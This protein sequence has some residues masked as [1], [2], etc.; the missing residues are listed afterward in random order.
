M[1]R[2]QFLAGAG[3]AGAALALPAWARESADAYYQG[4][5]AALKLH[6]WLGGYAGVDKDLDG[7]PIR[8]EGKLPKALRGTLHRNGPALL[9]RAGQ[10][11][12]HWFDGDGMVQAYEFSDRGLTHRGRFVRTRKFQAESAPASAKRRR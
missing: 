11:Y 2:R 1:A 4:F 3:F 10:R 5:H 12:H 9:E 6:P 7:G 8:F